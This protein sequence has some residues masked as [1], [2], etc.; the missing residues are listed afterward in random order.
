MPFSLPTYH[1]PR[2]HESPLAGAPLARFAPAPADGVAPQG[3]HA[4]SIF[5]EYL[6][7]EP[8]VWRLLKQSRM[9]CVVARTGHGELEVVEFRHL[10]AGQPVALGR[11]ENGEDGIYLHTTAFSPPAQAADKFAFRG[12]L[13]RESPFSIDYDQLYDL[14]RFERGHGCIVW[15][16]G[17]A[18]VFDADARQAMAG[19]IEDGY[20]HAVLAGNALATHDLE[21]SLLGTALGQEIYS[22]RRAALGHYHHLDVINTMRGLG[23]IQ[24]AL[25]QGLV[26]DG[27]VR[28]CLK[29]GLPLVLAGSIRDDGPLPGVIADV[30]Q[31]QDRMRQI[32]RRA[33]TVL[34]LAT[35]LH[36]I[37]AG[38]MVP[39]YQVAEDGAVRPVYFYTV[40]MSEFAANKLADRGS[41]TARA[42][43]TNVQ[44]FVVNL[45]RG[46][47]VKGC[48][49][50]GI[51]AG[52]GLDAPGA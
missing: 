36:A 47:G 21:A 48:P 52:G 30:Y 32:L 28:A 17:P 37:A 4:T 8:G 45:A 15:V 35:Q 19:L 43:L 31:A 13:S 40:D 10:Q 14:L 18:L 5:P 25:E 34:G 41:L 46:L 23:G 20:A 2:F 39:S 6:Q 26:K 42:I 27:V 50:P 12:Q 51:E 22:Q 49:A 1:P 7:V 3:Y 33:T 24:A 44:D 29:K 16:L 38:N 11:R 9:D